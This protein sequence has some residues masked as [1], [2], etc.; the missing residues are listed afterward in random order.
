[1][2]PAQ[3]PVIR[4]AAGQPIVLTPAELYH[5]QW[6]ERQILDRHQ[7]TLGYEIPITTMTS[8]QKRVVEQKFFTLPPARYLPVVAGDNAWSTF[9]TGYRAFQVGDNFETGIIDMG[10]DNAKLAQ[11]KVAVDALQ[12]K[13]INWAKEINWSLAELQQFAKD[14]NFDLVASLEKSRKTNWDLGIQRVAFLGARQRNLSGGDCFGLLNQPSA[15]INTTL[16]TSPIKGLSSA[17][18]KTFCTDVYEA[19]RLNCDRTATPTHF[20][21]PESDYNGLAG[22]SSPDFP[23]KS[24]KQV[25]EDTFR[26]VTGVEDFKILPCAYGDTAYHADVTPIAGKQ[27]YALYNG[28]DEDTIRMDVPVPYTATLGNTPNG[29]NM[30]NVAYGQFT[31][32]FLKR[33]LELL[34]FQY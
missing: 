22:Q 21:M 9:L 3:R 13:V 14:G 32:V 11:T 7:N 15:N 16:I 31:G 29:F 19:Y 8:I 30:A 24:I 25:L 12:I 28:K 17:D 1:M 5:A 10:G 18:L 33:P 27:V 2:I 20:T 4:N 23:I 26:E 34:Y 6:T